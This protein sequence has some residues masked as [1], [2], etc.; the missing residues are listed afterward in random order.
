M[1]DN[2]QKPEVLEIYIKYGDGVRFKE[3][4]AMEKALKDLGYKSSGSRHDAENH[5]TTYIY[6]YDQ[7]EG[8]EK[9]IENS[10]S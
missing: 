3:R 7:T 9:L 6:E 2:M 8:R 5:I 1:K 10:K 4:A